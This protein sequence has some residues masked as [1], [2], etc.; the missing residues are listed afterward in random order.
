MVPSQPPP[1]QMLKGKTTLR[2]YYRCAEGIDLPWATEFTC[3]AKVPHPN[4]NPDPQVLTL[5]EGGHRLKTA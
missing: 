2:S 5:L 4:L 1:V 3:S